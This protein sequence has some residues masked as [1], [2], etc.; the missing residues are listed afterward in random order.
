MKYCVPY[1]NRNEAEADR[2]LKTR[3]ITSSHSCD[4]HFRKDLASWGQRN[5]EDGNRGEQ[6]ESS[7]A[8]K[9]E[10]Q[11]TLLPPREAH[12]NHEKLTVTLSLTPRVM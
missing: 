7:S 1:Y 10:P 8:E 11:G 2:C 4:K 12:S 5:L 9:D 6:Q 3:K